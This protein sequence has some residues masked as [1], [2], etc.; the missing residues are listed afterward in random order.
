MSNERIAKALD[1][2]LTKTHEEWAEAYGAL[3]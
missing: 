1:G 2:Q 3:S